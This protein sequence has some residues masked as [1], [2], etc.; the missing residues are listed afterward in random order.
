MKFLNAKLKCSLEQLINSHRGYM[1]M[2][3]PLG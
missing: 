3:K 2:T 1:L